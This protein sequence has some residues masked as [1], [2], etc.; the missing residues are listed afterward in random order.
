MFMKLTKCS[1]GLIILLIIISY[2]WMSYVRNGI[3]HDE[4]SLWSDVVSKSHRKARVHFN[5]GLAYQIK[6]KIDKAINH[7]RLGLIFAPDDVDAHIKLGVCYFTAGKVDEAIR[8]FKHALMIDPKNA[9]AHYNLGVAYGSKGM[10]EQAY[11]EIKK[12]KDLS[13]Q[14]EWASLIGKTPK[15]PVH[16]P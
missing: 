3:W 11:Q 1:E 12:A 4:V 8:E 14:Q 7:Y 9:E 16:H 13:T 2:A 15:R 10:N 5:L 6:E